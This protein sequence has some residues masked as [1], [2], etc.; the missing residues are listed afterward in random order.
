MMHRFRIELNH[1]LLNL[2]DFHAYYR[3]ATIYCCA[4]LPNL[5]I[6]QRAAIN[7]CAV[8]LQIY[9]S[10]HNFIN[11]GDQFSGK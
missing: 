11:F 4:I 8:Y 2:S 6:M 1:N 3:R 5:W 10:I 7:L 9:M